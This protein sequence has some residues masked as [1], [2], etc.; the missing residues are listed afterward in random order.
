M[1]INREK[2][3]QFSKQPSFLYDKQPCVSVKKKILFDNQQ[4]QLLKINKSYEKTRTFDS[5]KS[6]LDHSMNRLNLI[7]KDLPA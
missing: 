4:E 1:L 5:P 7:T 2:K 6:K 3:I